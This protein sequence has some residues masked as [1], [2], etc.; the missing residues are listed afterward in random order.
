MGL[1]GGGVSAG[2]A[3]LGFP[4]YMETMH[5]DWLT[6]VDGL[7]TTLQPGASPFNDAFAYDPSTNIQDMEEK[8]EDYQT[9]IDALEPEDDFDTY[10]ANAT[11]E[12]DADMLS[13]SYITDAVADAEASRKPA[14]YRSVNSFTAGM[15][16]LNAVHNS[17]FVI[18]LG[19]LER[20][21][22]AEIGQFEGQMRL[23]RD[24]TRF[25]AILQATGFM[26][27]LHTA[28]LQARGQIATLQIDQGRTAIIAQ[29]EETQTNTQ[30]DAADLMWDFDLYDLAGS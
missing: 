11:A 10:L 18:G 13:D 14:Y 30:Y 26:I 17:A 4:T 2:S 3:D 16:D 1:G 27:Q 25:A 5:D 9:D 28:K 7:I 21:F 20:G 6:E 23:R 12:I 22:N 15:N 19:M 24:A 29:A 8:L